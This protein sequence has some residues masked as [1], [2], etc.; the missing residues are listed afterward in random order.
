MKP[1]RESR[2][3]LP[4]LTITKAIEASE[5]HQ[6]AKTWKLLPQAKDTSLNVPEDSLHIKTALSV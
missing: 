2:D 3:H 1:H 6:Y 5:L 4:H